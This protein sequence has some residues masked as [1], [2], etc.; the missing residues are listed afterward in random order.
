[1]TQPT[2]EPEINGGG[3]FQNDNVLKAQDFRVLVFSRVLVLA[4]TTLRSLSL[5]SQGL[6]LKIEVKQLKK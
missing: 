3:H 4:C 5:T 2:W 1:M 6:L